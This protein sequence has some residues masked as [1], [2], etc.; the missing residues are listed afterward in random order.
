LVFAAVGALLLLGVAGLGAA[1][2][3]VGALLW[4]WLLWAIA[5]WVLPE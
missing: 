2:G 4:S 5:A 3:A 1:L